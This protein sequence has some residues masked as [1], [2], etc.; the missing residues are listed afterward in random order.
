MT[1]ILTEWPDDEA[2]I[3]DWCRPLSST[4]NSPRS[5][6][7]TAHRGDDEHHADKVNYAA[8]MLRINKMRMKK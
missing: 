6:S 2:P 5:L 1:D 7:F 8:V 3:R 4:V